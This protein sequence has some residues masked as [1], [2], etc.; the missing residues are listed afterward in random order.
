MI[1]AGSQ[2]P[3]GPPPRYPPMK[4]A[5]INHK[6]LAANQMRPMICL[7]RSD[8]EPIDTIARKTKVNKIHDMTP[9]LALRPAMCCHAGTVKTVLLRAIH[10]DGGDPADE[11]K[12]LR[13]AIPRMRGTEGGDAIQRRGKPAY[14]RRM[15]R[16]GGVPGRAPGE[17]KKCE[18]NKRAYFHAGHVS[19]AFAL[20][21]EEPSYALLLHI[22]VSFAEALRAK[23]KSGREPLDIHEG[24][25]PHE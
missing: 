5:K 18:G 21:K 1:M 8:R 9:L 7:P 12:A 25:I 17:R 20:C 10:G 22:P 2:Y 23:A 13:R 16:I 3:I 11:A 14:G 24:M 19:A 6:M 15:R 4:K